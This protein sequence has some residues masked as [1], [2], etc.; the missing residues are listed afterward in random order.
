MV[1]PRLQVVAVE[2][3]LVSTIYSLISESISFSF[4]NWLLLPFWSKPLLEGHISSEEN[5]IA[6]TFRSLFALKFVGIS[7]L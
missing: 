2:L 1:V 5:I 4:E 6:L 7:A 3:I